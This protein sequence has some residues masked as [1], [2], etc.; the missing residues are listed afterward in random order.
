MTV[1][2]PASMPPIASAPANRRTEVRRRAERPEDV[3]GEPREGRW[4]VKRA[5]R[6]ERARNADSG[7]A[8]REDNGWNRARA[9]LDRWARLSRADGHVNRDTTHD[10]CG[11]REGVCDDCKGE[12][13]FLQIQAV[14]L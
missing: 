3:M 6:S 12:R 5:C 9:G 11:T 1:H 10:N 8:R 2:A 4:T 14:L 7:R 13:F